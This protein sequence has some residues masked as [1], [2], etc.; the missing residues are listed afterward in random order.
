MKKADTPWLPLPDNTAEKLNMAAIKP[1]AKKPGAKTQKV[2]PKL[3]QSR[4]VFAVKKE[5]VSREYCSYNCRAAA[6]AA[7]VGSQYALLCPS[8]NFPSS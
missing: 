1:G 6:G 8:F 7:V 3:R 4:L 2:V 5:T